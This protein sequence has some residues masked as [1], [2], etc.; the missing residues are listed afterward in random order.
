MSSFLQL[1]VFV[2]LTVDANLKLQDKPKASQKASPRFVEGHT[3]A[4]DLG[5]CSG[6]HSRCKRWVW[7]A[8]IAAPHDQKG[9]SR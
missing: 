1:T 6:W 4:S 3:S 2:M 7:D 8:A 9:G 5:G